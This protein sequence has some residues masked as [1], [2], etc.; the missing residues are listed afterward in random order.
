M[1]D[2]VI[3]PHREPR[4]HVTL[5]P[6]RS[7]HAEPP[8][9]VTSTPSRSK[10]PGPVTAPGFA[11]TG[12]E[13][14]RHFGTS[15]VA[16][17]RMY[18]Q[19]GMVL[20]FSWSADGL[21]LKGKCYGSGRSTYQQ[22]IHFGG[23][24]SIPTIKVAHCTCPVGLSCKHVVAIL[25]EAA[26]SSARETDPTLDLSPTAS[27]RAAIADIVDGTPPAIS[28]QKGLA[29]AVGLTKTSRYSTSQHVQLR[30]ML[31]GARQPWVKTGAAWSD[32]VWDVRINAEAAQVSA[33]QAIYREL[34]SRGYGTTVEW[35]S[36]MSSSPRIWHLIDDAV[37][38][39]VALV[40]ARDLG[41]SALT[42]GHADV[43]YAI[44]HHPDGACLTRTI[45]VN[46]EPVDAKAVE[47][48]GNPA[49][50]GLWTLDGGHLLLAG[51]GGSRSATEID[52]ARRGVE[53]LI[54]AT[55]LVEFSTEALPKL[56]QARPTTVAEG[57]FT[58]PTIE[59]PEAVL[60]LS[61]TGSGAR[62]TWSVGYRINEKNIVFNPSQASGQTA[63]RDADAEDSLWRQVRPAMEAV[64]TQSSSW[65]QN[66]A[67][68]P[69]ANADLPV[70]QAP[71]TLTR[72]ELAV[73]M[74]EIV[75]ELE[76]TQSLRVDNRIG[77]SYT[78]SPH[79]PSIAF[80]ADDDTGS[81]D[82]FGLD[83]AILLG[84]QRVPTADVI[85]ELA[86][87]AT[88]MLLPND[89][90]FSMDVP[91]LHKLAELLEE[92]RSLGE[93]DSGTFSKHSLNATFW[94]ELLELGVVD[95]QLAQWR[96]RMSDLASAEPPTP[97]TPSRRLHADL[98][99]Y[100]RDGLNWLSFLWKHGLGGVL[101]D[102][103]GLGKTVQTLALIARATDAKRDRRFLV[104]APTSVVPNWVAECRKFVPSLTVT[105]ITATPKR[106]GAS[107]KDMVG[108]AQV[109]VTSYGLLRLIVDGL[110]EFT[111]DGIIF[112]E[113]Q[114]IKNHAG[115]THQC[116]RRL[117]SAFKLAITGTPMENNL[118]EL[119]SLL[120]VTA[121]GLF[122]SPV[123]FTDYFRKPIESGSE[124]ERLATLRRRIKP[125][126]L[127]RTK[128]QVAVDLPPKQEQALVL[129]LSSKHRGIYDT[130]LA[131]ERQKVLG[132]L[133]DWEKNRF[134]IFSSLTMLRQLSLHAG[135]VD[136]TQYDVGSA[137]I[138]YL[139]EQLPTLIDEGHSAL[140]FSQFTGFL[141]LVRKHLDEL[142]IVYSYLDGTMTAAKRA[143]AVRQFTS[144]ATQ[145]FLIS[146]KAGG[147]GLNLTEADYC[148]VCD[149]WWNPA[150]EA[151]AIDRAHRIGQERPVTV[152]RLVSADTI[153]ERVVKLQDKK[154]ALFDAVVDD[155][156]LFGT[157]LDANDIREMLG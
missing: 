126:M 109:V 106:S 29:L 47:V 81:G 139:T 153:E 68:D 9:W 93:I 157:A 127:R 100:Q 150:A 60:T 112:D 117:D 120:S 63:Y 65:L 27:W 113:A 35:L 95:K 103:M 38:A 143:A 33:I 16:R 55:D 44:G 43:R 36:L 98:R 135:L 74:G 39:G 64:V 52:C 17:G 73:L 62:Y 57:V 34:T 19:Q 2:L 85:R 133:G 101:A 25:L 61:E 45:V 97:V 134:Q 41:I 108:D 132:L 56:Q 87:G 11:A 148:F 48:I 118:M 105:S 110:D 80:A 58:P 31:E 155:G 1:A 26:K 91:E 22:T 154:R 83:V 111:W 104:V 129:D 15:T 151:Q 70:L 144:G 136:S 20:D 90:Y 8:H 72:T 89:E 130:R 53:S 92:A 124:P 156:E 78:R 102:D 122:P 121:P 30:P 5:P 76:R 86:S 37:A 18:A 23:Y 49:P 140:V 12:A 24:P 123:A 54:P 59:G 67:I 6:G 115:K 28:R 131:R 99:D 71:G 69:V 42:L 50:H 3:G 96:K 88:H 46:D 116:A 32:V 145:V 7:G 14:D 10:Y 149:P 125:V 51:F 152:Y 142:G 77:A 75:P 21:V 40:P 138:E 4:A 66:P 107:V 146:L 147:F 82:W 114:F 137:K 94:E 141:D 13:L 128:S 79:T 84:R 119:W